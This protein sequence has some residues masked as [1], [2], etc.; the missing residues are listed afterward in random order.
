M[1]HK[2]NAFMLKDT[3]VW[4]LEQDLLRL[5]DLLERGGTL[6]WCRNGEWRAIG[7]PQLVTIV[8]RLRQHGTI[9][10]SYI[11]ADLAYKAPD[12]AYAYDEW[13]RAI[14]VPAEVVRWLREEAEQLGKTN[15]ATE[16]ATE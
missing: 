12:Q 10:Q 9:R 13:D 1:I 2:W 4:D 7:G 5:S 11:T 15:P 3:P 14:P 6:F 16:S 8:D